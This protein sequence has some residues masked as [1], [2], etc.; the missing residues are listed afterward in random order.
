MNDVH[1]PQ[2]SHRLKGWLAAAV[3]LAAALPLQALLAQAPPA[4]P[5]SAQLPL[6]TA[7]VPLATLVQLAQ[8]NSA[9]VHM[10][11]ANVDKATS[12]MSESRDTVIPSVSFSSG[13]PTG[14]QIGFT[15]TP[16]SVMSASVQS[17]VFGFPQKHY[18]SAAGYGV[19]A[20]IANLK[21]AREQAALDASIAY[22][23]LDTLAAELAVCRQQED[24][25]LRMVQIEQER[26]EAGVDPLSAVLDARLVSAEIRLKRMQLEARAEALRTQLAA[27]TGMNIA[28]IKTAHESIPEIPQ[29]RG[30]AAQT[31]PSIQAAEFQTQSRIQQARADHE[32]NFLPQLTFGAQY[33]RSTVLFNTV[34]KYFA[35]P[36]PAN[37]F[38]SGISIQVPIFNMSSHAKARESAADAL[39]ARV[40]AEQASQQNDQQIAS[41]TASLREMDGLAEVAS[42]KKQIAEEQLKSILSQLELGSGSS[43][44]PQ[45]SP[46]AEQQARIDERQ[47]ELD[48]L[49]ASFNLARTR[50]GLL[51]A[52]GHIDDWLNELQHK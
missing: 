38:S 32:I 1:A 17:L 50:L 6:A 28:L 37:N 48:A 52:L 21:E 41:L 27:L 36:L 15:G 47:K 46:K 43:S 30:I 40:E 14:S 44:Q 7:Q 16:P 31:L 2:N 9:A 12:L 5:P 8:R 26:S 4:L 49:D 11:Q 19:K 39:K 25:A 22:V 20:A 51:R 3:A 10:A 18:L 13:L 45:L 24:Y 29:V 23:E 35:S 33:N 34:D 42:L